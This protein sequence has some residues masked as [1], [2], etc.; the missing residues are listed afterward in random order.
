M[1][2]MVTSNVE[3]WLDEFGQRYAMPKDW[4][5]SMLDSLQLASLLDEHL[6]RGQSKMKLEHLILDLLNHSEVWNSQSTLANF[7]ASRI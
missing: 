3:A 7:L 5:L 2:A 6:A 1:M 4:N